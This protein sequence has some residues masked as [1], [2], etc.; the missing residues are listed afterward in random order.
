MTKIFPLSPFRIVFENDYM[1]QF[2]QIWNILAKQLFQHQEWVQ[3][4]I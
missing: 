3:F 4:L 1:D 2:G